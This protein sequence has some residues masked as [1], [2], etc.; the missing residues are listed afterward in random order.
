MVHKYI[1]SSAFN[2][3]KMRVCE[4]VWNHQQQVWFKS[5]R[6]SILE[7]ST[8]P[9]PA[10]CA[11]CWV[12]VGSWSFGWHVSLPS[13]DDTACALQKA[14]GKPKIRDNYV[15]FYA[16]DPTSFSPPPVQSV[17]FDETSHSITQGQPYEGVSTL[18]YYLDVR[19]G[20]HESEEVAQ[21]FQCWFNSRQ[22]LG[23]EHIWP[24]YPPTIRA[25]LCGFCN[26]S[27]TINDVTRVCPEMRIA[28]GT[29]LPRTIG[30]LQAQ[31][32]IGKTE[33]PPVRADWRA[34]AA[35]AMSH[36]MNA[37]QTINSTWSLTSENRATQHLRENHCASHCAEVQVTCI[38]RCWKRTNM[39][40]GKRDGPPP[41]R[42]PH[43]FLTVMY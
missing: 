43:S 4:P 5:D 33:R 23:F 39:S 8:R 29:S 36:F 2:D 42:L 25:Q 37:A 34:L 19:A 35:I 27:V 32:A 14:L 30:G 11:T 31:R 18:G 9:F 21:R 24:A 26:V 13:A 12:V 1:P 22:C 16:Y 28:Q 17:Q 20:R 10:S 40:C 7:F 38:F 3:L 6:R 41:K 15:Y